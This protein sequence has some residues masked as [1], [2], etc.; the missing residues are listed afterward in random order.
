M[1]SQSYGKPKKDAWFFQAPW[2]VQFFGFCISHTPQCIQSG[3]HSTST[4]HGFNM[5]LLLYVYVLGRLK[6]FPATRLVVSQWQRK[7]QKMCFPLRAYIPVLPRGTQ[8][9]YMPRD[10][11]VGPVTLFLYYL[12]EMGLLY[13]D[14]LTCE[15]CLCDR[16]SCR[17]YRT[18]Y[19]REAR[20]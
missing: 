19:D 4:Q 17:L 12:Y 15:D 5:F 14:M 13:Y 18:T 20:Q 1:N 16:K 6:P 3:L 8:P 10:G 11:S 9:H 2:Q 7:C